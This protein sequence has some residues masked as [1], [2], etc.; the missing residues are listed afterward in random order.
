MSRPPGAAS[1]SEILVL[2]PLVEGIAESSGKIA[3][4][5]GIDIIVL[6]SNYRSLRGRT[7]ARAILGQASLFEPVV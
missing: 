7:V 1:S 3:L 2:A 4:G 5:N 6:L